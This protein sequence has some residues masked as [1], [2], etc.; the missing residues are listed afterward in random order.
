M[1]LFTD[2]LLDEVRNSVNIVS[3][4]SEYVALKKRGRNHVAR[5]PFHSERTPSFN[6]NE[7]KQMFH[8][9]GC[10]VG[11]DVFKFMMMVELLS[12]PDAVRLLAERNGVSI[13]RNLPAADESHS[14]L[15]ALRKAMTEAAAFFH[16][17]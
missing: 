13:P 4:V 1:P 2:G 10:G 5:R 7:D 8:C 15:E 14:D 17:Q 12:F 9:F 16:H 11:G 6:V 3:F